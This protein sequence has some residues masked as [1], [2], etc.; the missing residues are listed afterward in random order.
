MGCEKGGKAIKFRYAP[1]QWD[2][3]WVL[4]P[5]YTKKYKRPGFS[6]D[7][8]KRK[9]CFDSTK[10]IILRQTE[11]SLFATLDS[12]KYFFQILFFKSG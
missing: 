4:K 10:K 1:I 6:Y 9:R 12:D 3:W 2:G 7:S 5:E 11:P 8:P